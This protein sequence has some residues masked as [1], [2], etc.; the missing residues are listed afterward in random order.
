MSCYISFLTDWYL[1]SLN[2]R[3]KMI[4]PKFH[5]ISLSDELM[6]SVSPLRV[7]T[8]HDRRVRHLNRNSSHFMDTSPWQ[9]PFLLSSHSRHQW[10]QGISWC[11]TKKT[12]IRISRGA[13]LCNNNHHHSARTA[14]SR[15]WTTT[16]S[17][18]PSKHNFMNRA[19]SFLR[20]LGQHAGKENVYR[21]GSDLI[22]SE[23][24]IYLSF[25]RTF[26]FWQV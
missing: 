12:K 1:V 3:V 15:N 24:G 16:I 21:T 10:S 26:N 17:H 4:S 18:L 20:S 25:Q 23:D 6:Y 22:L 13:R 14:V 2:T 19:F 7:T 8:K 5:I 11:I 9:P